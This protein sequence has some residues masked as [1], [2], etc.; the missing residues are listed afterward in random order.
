[1]T[2]VVTLEARFAMIPEWVLDAATSRG[3]HVYGLLMR[4]ATKAADFSD[5][6]PARP[7]LAERMQCSLSTI[8]RALVDLVTIGAVQI[9]PRFDET[10]GNRQTSNEYHLLFNP[11]LVTSEEGSL[12]TDADPPLVTGAE[13]LTRALSI[14]SPL[15][16][17]EGSK[18]AIVLLSTNPQYRTNL[19]NALVSV[20]GWDPA[21][22]TKDGWGRIEAAAKQLSDIGA[23]PAEI[24]YR[25]GNYLVNN[26]GKLT[27]NALAVNWAD[28]ATRN[29]RPSLKD[30][31]RAAR[32][33][34]MIAE[35][36]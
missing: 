8:D 6:F 24:P 11:P 25:A 36:Q 26:P 10:A 19:K 33:E 23:D 30:L 20:M 31:E 34:R 18:R 32:G 14:D 29:P 4:Y 17:T 15:N 13:P 7:T 9:I 12:V 16:D 5:A 2:D 3:V 1:M 21:E 28:C 27:P 22:M 35:A